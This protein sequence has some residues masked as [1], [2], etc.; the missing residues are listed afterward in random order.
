MT[1]LR[2]S[3]SGPPVPLVNLSGAPRPTRRGIGRT[4][5][6]L[7][8]ERYDTRALVLITLAQEYGHVLYFSYSA[9]QWC[10]LTPL[11]LMI[12]LLR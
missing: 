6:A 3:R 9:Q 7:H 8:K 5:T 12:E 4:P 1:G 10:L 2:A 11:G